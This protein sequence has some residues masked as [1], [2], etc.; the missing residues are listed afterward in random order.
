M[1]KTVSLLLS[2]LVL[3]SVCLLSGCGDKGDTKTT[4]TQAPETS[5]TTAA[6]SAASEEAT[7]QAQTEATTAFEGELSCVAVGFAK[8]S[9]NLEGW[10]D[11]A[12]PPYETFVADDGE[13]SEYIAFMQNEG[14]KIRDFKFYRL[15]DVDFVDDKLTFNAEEIY[16][17][18]TL[19]DIDPIFIRMT[20]FG[21]MPSYGFSYI[22]EEGTKAYALNLSG[23]DG[24]ITFEEIEM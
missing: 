4:T 11:F 23:M 6:Q 2:V 24:S 13:Q 12:E 22:D 16:S 18:S 9:F 19:S 20:F 3:L 21:T 17:R 7:T 8:D 5:E 10:E 1:K 14:G 15:N